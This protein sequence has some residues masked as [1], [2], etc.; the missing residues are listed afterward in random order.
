MSTDAEASILFII[1]PISGGSTKNDWESVIREFYKSHRSKT[2]FFF[3]TGTDDSVSI[4]NKIEKI[5]PA[6]V[7]AVGGDGT[8]SIVAR[9]VIG[10]NVALGILPAGSANG[11]ATELGIPLNANEALEI[12]EN[13]TTRNADA[14]DVNNHVCL[15][16]SDIGLNAQLVKHFEEGKVRGKLG[17]ATKVI[18]T[19]WTKS[20]LSLKI[21]IRG[22]EVNMRALMV[23]LANAT[24]Y[25]TGAV[26]NP[27]G[28]LYDGQ[29]EVVIMKKLA[30]TELFKMWFKPQPF[31]PTK[32]KVYPATSV[33]IQT[34]RK[35]HFQVDGEYLGKVH[36]IDA[37]IIAGQLKLIV[38]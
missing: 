38:P 7:V 23:V 13:G 11:M 36:S 26:I 2:E 35:V 29:F 30:I 37:K 5:K 4:R 6:R 33:N 14:I 31:N 24:K 28:D 16:L 21:N 22:K 12:I 20:T 27:Q 1:N 32:I 9:E 19:L 25:G 15:H 18:K 10:K 17:Y 3:L 34:T 8:V